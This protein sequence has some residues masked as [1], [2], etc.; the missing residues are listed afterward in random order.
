MVTFVI[1]G[2]SLSAVLETVC[3][4]VFEI[5]T[6]LTIAGRNNFILAHRPLS[7]N[8]VGSQL[9]ERFTLMSRADRRGTSIFW[10]GFFVAPPRCARRKPSSSLTCYP[11]KSPARD[12]VEEECMVDV[13]K[14]AGAQ[15]LIAL[16]QSSSEAA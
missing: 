1:I 3:E 14:A 8:P 9:S 7:A 10:I 12:E 11:L 6:K 13:T 16:W 5:E 4:G 15:A 2:I